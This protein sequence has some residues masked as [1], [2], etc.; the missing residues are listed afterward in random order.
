M[1]LEII[2]LTHPFAER[3]KAGRQAMA[4][5]FFDG[6]HAGHREVLRRAVLHARRERMTASVMTFDPHPR[7]VLGKGGRIDYITPL[8]DK[9][10]QFASCGLERCYVLTFNEALA[11]LTPDEFVQRILFPL[12]VEHAVVGFNF[13]FGR[14]GSGNADTLRACGGGRLGVTV[15]RPHLQDGVKVSST[16]IREMI[17][18]GSMERVAELLGRPFSLTG[19]VVHGLGRGRTIGIPT[20][21]LAPAERYVIPGRGVYAVDARIDGGSERHRGVMNIGVKPTFADDPPEPTL[22]VHLI[23]FDG[24]LYGRTLKVEFLARI[25]DERKFPGADAL[26]AQIRRDI[27]EAGRVR[28]QPEKADAT[29]GC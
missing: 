4:I 22:E 2:R 9:L 7:E 3:P 26:I 12:E 17:H 18:Q 21:N 24:D 25:R 16:L 6:V 20:A 14:H 1:D 8:P 23:G 28:R 27:E 13:T 15:V 29:G 19:T 10:E 5:G 11:T